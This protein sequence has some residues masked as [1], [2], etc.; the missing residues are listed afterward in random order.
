MKETK[1]KEVGSEKIPSCVLRSECG[2]MLTYIELKVSYR[3]IRYP[4][5]LGLEILDG[6]ERENIRPHKITDYFQPGTQGGSLTFIIEQKDKVKKS[7]IARIA[8]ASIESV[9]GV[10]KD[11]ERDLIDFE[12]ADY[13]IVTKTEYELTRK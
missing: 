9:V 2:K 1:H 10:G 7:D 13:D 3:A 12:E 8:E 4:F 11:V 5:P 6:L